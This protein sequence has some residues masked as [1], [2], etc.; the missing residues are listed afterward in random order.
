MNSSSVPLLRDLP[1]ISQVGDRIED[2]LLRQARRK[3]LPAGSFDQRELFVTY[4]AVEGGGG[5]DAKMGMAPD[6]SG[7][8]NESQIR[9]SVGRYGP[10]GLY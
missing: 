8:G 6:P 7:Q 9:G 2:R 1:G 5:H 3:G 10:H 4:G